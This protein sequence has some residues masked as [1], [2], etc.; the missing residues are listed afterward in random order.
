MNNILLF[1]I[2]D[3][4]SISHFSPF[5][6]ELTFIAALF[7]AKRSMSF[8][9]ARLVFGLRNNFRNTKRFFT[10]FILFIEMELFTFASS[11]D[12]KVTQTALLLHKGANFLIILWSAGKILLQYDKLIFAG[13]FLCFYWISLLFH[14]AQIWIPPFSKGC[15]KILTVIFLWRR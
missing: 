9:I 15:S 10:N 4:V 12:S 1:D 2:S 13:V 3:Q 5:P 7:T 14:H 8:D 6:S 11:L